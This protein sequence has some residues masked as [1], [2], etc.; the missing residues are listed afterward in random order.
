MKAAIW[1]Q[2]VACTVFVAASA[3]GVVSCS[4]DDT[5]P[6]PSTPAVDAGTTPTPAAT[7]VQISVTDNS[8]GPAAMTIAQGTTVRWT[9]NGVSLHSV[10]SGT[11]LNDANRAQ[12]FDR[13]IDP[14]AT[15][16]HT[17][18][19]VGTVDYFCKYHVALGMTGSITV[20]SV[21]NPT[22]K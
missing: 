4:G 16:E 9:N 7:T 22:S 2:V 15:F 6:A 13:D 11:G 5:S 8:F 14:G 12:V 18:N 20:Q 3:A 21:A 19:D 10:T 1:Q 17:F